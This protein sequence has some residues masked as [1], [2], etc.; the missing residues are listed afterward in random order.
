LRVFVLHNGD[1]FVVVPGGLVRVLETGGDGLP[2]IPLI[3]LSKDVWVMPEGAGTS[4][5]PH[6]GSAPLPHIEGASSDVPSRAADN[7][8]WLGRYTERLEEIVRSARYALGCVG[9]DTDASSQSRLGPL[10]GILGRLG[11]VAA[12]ENA[13]NRESLIQD[14]L[15]LVYDE[16]PAE[17]V[18]DLLQR[19]HLAAFSV[20]DRLST[21]T[22]HLLNRLKTHAQPRPGGLPLVGTSGTLH[23]LVLDLAAFSGME[24]ENMT[25]GHGW[26]FLDMGRRIER[27]IFIARLMEAVGRS[28][29]CLDWVVE[30]ALEIADSVMTHRRRYFTE[31]RLSSVMEVLVEDASNPR[32]LAF[33]VACLKEHAALLPTGQNPDGVGALRVLVGQI[34]DCLGRF[35]RAGTGDASTA[36]ELLPSTCE[37]IAGR[38]AALSESLTEVYFSHISSRVS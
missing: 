21:D 37:E 22:W 23:A 35:S 16:E 4:P 12:P 28:G 6:A 15:S 30:P 1:E 18:R 33:Q 11:L 38:L 24:M 9:E 7:L 36:A 10:Q 25:R 5:L 8:F 14:L 20:R 26:V 2:P 27:A 34:D 29:R 32:S 17:G 19:I 3:G 31:P 13:V